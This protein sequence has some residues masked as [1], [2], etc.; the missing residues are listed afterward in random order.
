MSDHHHPWLDVQWH[1]SFTWTVLGAIPA[2]TERVAL[3]T[4]VT[5]PMVRCHPEIIAQAAATLALGLRRPFR[6]GRGFR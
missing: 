2:R 6:P 4:G 3:V 1:F 5:C